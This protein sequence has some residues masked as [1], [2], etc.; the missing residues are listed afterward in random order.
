[1][2]NL[3]VLDLRGNPLEAGE[4][5]KVKIAAARLARSDLIFW[6][7]C[8]VVFGLRRFLVQKVFTV[9]M[10]CALQYPTGYRPTSQYKLR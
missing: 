3:A 1:M 6:P 2:E 9:V 4:T 5:G 10:V 7:R 8:K